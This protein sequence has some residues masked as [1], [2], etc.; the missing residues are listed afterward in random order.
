MYHDNDKNAKKHIL[1]SDKA[2]A[3]YYELISNQVWGDINNYELCID[4]KIGNDEVIK[5]ICEYI[6]KISK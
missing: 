1:D 4:C 5:I 3:K 2:R 6:S